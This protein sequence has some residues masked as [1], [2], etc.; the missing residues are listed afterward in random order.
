MSA[1]VETLEMQSNVD[2]GNAGDDAATDYNWIQ[3]VNTLRFNSLAVR[4]AVPAVVARRLG[5]QTLSIAVQGG[6]LGLWT[7]YRGLDPNVNG[8][9]TGNNVTDTGVLPQPRTWQLQVRATY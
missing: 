6:N 8:F 2:V 1:I 7:N 3:T 5:A 9:G 4:Y